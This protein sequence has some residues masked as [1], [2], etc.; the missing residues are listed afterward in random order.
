MLGLRGDPAMVNDP[1][2]LARDLQTILAISR[3]MGSER[4]LDRLLELI[5]RAV[6]DLAG[7]DRTSLYL[8]DAEHQELITSISQG[9]RRIRLPLGSGIAGSV[10]ASGRTVNIP[11][12]YADPRFNREHDQRS[13]YITRSI[14][15]MPLINH[16]G[17]VVGVIQALNKRNGEPFGEYD[18]QVLSALCGNA[19]VAIDNAQ[20]IAR[21]RDR[22][23]LER[24]MELARQI[25]LSLLPESPPLHARWRLAAWAQSCDQTGGDYYDFIALPDGGIDAVIGDVS[26]HGIAAALLMGTARAFLRALH[27]QEREPGAIVTSLNR[28]LERDL[29]DESFMSLA[30]CR[31]GADGGCAYVAAGHE[32][33]LVLRR[34]GHFDDLESSGLPIGMMDDSVYQATAIAPLAAGEVLVLFTDGI[35]EAQAPPDFASWG[36]E[37]F[38]RTVAG[39]A[40]G[41]AQAVCDAV[42]AGAKAH[43]RG[44]QP[45]DDMTLVV[46][47]RLPDPE[48]R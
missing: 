4:D 20:L 37:A 9:A 17:G 22:Q 12:A 26:G 31:L 1:A 23:R 24:D 40:S 45:H 5:V 46:I 25:Q 19:A 38:K 7:A 6:T 14:L 42:V 28:L 27:E 35:F 18:E 8:V 36:L 39:H 2:R 30:M 44:H 32:P 29:N 15:C 48:P 34:D 47:E 43:L 41:G 33:P 11:H 3:A 21:D 16:A 10:A 13:G